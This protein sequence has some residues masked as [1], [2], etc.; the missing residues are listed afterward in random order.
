MDKNMSLLTA[1]M[2]CVMEAAAAVLTLCSAI[3]A[4]RTR[5]SSV[6][7]PLYCDPP[8]PAAPLPTE[9]AVA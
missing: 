5:S 4:H 1:Y 8:D 3:C 2:F 7:P 6:G 9:L